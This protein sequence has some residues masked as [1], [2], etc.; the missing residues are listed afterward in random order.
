M[1]AWD[2]HSAAVSGAY[3]G[4]G[5]ENVHLAVHEFAVVEPKLIALA[6][7][8][9]PGVDADGLT[10]AAHVGE[11]FVNKEGAV[12][13]VEGAFP[14]NKILDLIDP[15]GMVNQIFESGTGFIDLLQIEAVCAAVLVAVNVSRPVSNIQ[16]E[17]GV[18]LGVA[19]GD[20]IGREGVFQ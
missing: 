15:G 7:V 9:P 4:E 2:H 20:L 10:R 6:D 18:D 19:G 8:M 16:G 12:V 13:K 5:D 11:V 1:A 14:S 3:I 17:D